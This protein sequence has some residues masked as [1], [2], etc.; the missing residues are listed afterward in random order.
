VTEKLRFAD[1]EKEFLE[2]VGRIVWCTVSTIDGKGRP[3]SR[4]L[5]PVW[6]GA[7]GWIAT[8]RH[9]LKTKHLAKNPNVALSYWDAQHDTAVVQARAEWC[10]DAATKSRIWNLLKNSPP[11]IGY[12]PQLFWR[13]G[14]TDPSFGVLKLTPFQIQLLTGAEMMQGKSARLC[15]F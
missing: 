7:T 6:E 15:R 12:D 13:A 1:I 11:P 4:I 8:G 2:R 5:H 10:D 9:T 14:V 3:Y